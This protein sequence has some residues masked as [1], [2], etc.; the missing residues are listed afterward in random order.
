[1]SKENK[2]FET[3]KNED[4]FFTNN[5]KEMLGKF[6]AERLL[7]GWK[8]D[9]VDEDSG[10]VVSID[11]SEVIADRGALI[12]GDLLAR[13]NFHIQCGDI[14]E[15]EVSNQRREAFHVKNTYLNP[16]LAVVKINDKNTK[17]LLYAASVEMAIEVVKDYVELNYSNGFFVSQMKEFTSC[18]ILNDNLKSYKSDTDAPMEC[19]ESIMEAEEGNDDSDYKFYQIEVIITTDEHTYSS[20][21]IVKTKDV[22]KAMVVIRNYVAGQMHKN[23]T[24]CEQLDIKLETAKILP[25]NGFI[26]KEFSLAYAE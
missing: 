15:V 24:I 19:V 11:R 22:D 13:I 4:R 3:R 8:E 12:D 5:P 20:L 14:K 17:F 7:R 23:K 2:T 18:I 6:I 25:V 1:M 9:F 16:Y 21:F 26:E 10:E